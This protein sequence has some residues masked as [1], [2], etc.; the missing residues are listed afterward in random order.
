MNCS[1]NNIKGND[2]IWFKW[3]IFCIFDFCFVVAVFDQVHD[4]ETI[5]GIC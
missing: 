1:Y 2:V 5:H 4:V 3:L